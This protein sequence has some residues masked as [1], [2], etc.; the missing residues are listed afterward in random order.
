MTQ[1][2]DTNMKLKTIPTKCPHCKA[3]L[4]DRLKERQNNTVHRN[5]PKLVKSKNCFQRFCYCDNCK[6]YWYEIFTISE[7]DLIED[8]VRR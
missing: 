8:D 3:K 7:V 5:P 6:N 1:E 2:E 4:I